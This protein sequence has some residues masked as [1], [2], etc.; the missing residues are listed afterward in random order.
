MSSFYPE[1]SD[2]NGKNYQG[3]DIC[4]HPSLPRFLTL[5]KKVQIKDI[6]APSSGPLRTPGKQDIDHMFGGL[7]PRGG[8]TSTFH[9]RLAV[10]KLLSNC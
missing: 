4:I 3:H 6:D 1:L 2:G 7:N 5:R 8:S 9:H 10:R